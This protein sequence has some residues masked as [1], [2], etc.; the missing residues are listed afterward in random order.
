MSGLAGTMGLPCRNTFS[1]DQGTFPRYK[2]GPICQT[3]LLNREDA[4]CMTHGMSLA[5]SGGRLDCPYGMK[6]VLQM[7]SD[8]PPFQ[9][10]S[11]ATYD[12]AI[13]FRN[14]LRILKHSDPQ[15]DLDSRK[16][17][18]HSPSLQDCL[19]GINQ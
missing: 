18:Q 19:K 14:P 1:V 15:P 4:C 2:C 5:Y 3:F 7:L 9:P 6:V 12:N 16:S 11:T 8:A 10:C 17:P 13:L